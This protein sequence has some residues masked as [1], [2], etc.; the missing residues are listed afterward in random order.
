MA[1]MFGFGKRAA[2]DIA[3]TVR[4]VR[5][6]Y[7]NEI[8]QGRGGTSTNSNKLARITAV[9]PSNDLETGALVAE[10]ELLFCNFPEEEGHQV[11]TTEV[12]ETRVPLFAGGTVSNILE[13]DQIWTV[14]F[15]SGQWWLGNIVS[16]KPELIRKACMIETL[17]EGENFNAKFAWLMTSIAG[18][19]QCSNPGGAMWERS[20]TQICVWGD[21]GFRGVAFGSDDYV[22][23]DADSNGT[24]VDVYYSAQHRKWFALGGYT[25]LIGSVVGTGGAGSDITTP[26]GNIFGHGIATASIE[27]DAITCFVGDDHIGE[28]VICHW[29]N[30]RQVWYCAL[31]GCSIPDP[32]TTTTTTTTT[33]PIP[34][35][36]QVDDPLHFTFFSLEPCDFNE[37]EVLLDKISDFVWEWSGTLDCGDLFTVTYTCNPLADETGC[38]PFTMHYTFPCAGY[39]EDVGLTGCNCFGDFTAEVV[40]FGDESECECCQTPMPCEEN[41]C[42]TCV[43]IYHDEEH[44]FPDD[45]GWR[46]QSSSCV[47][48]CGTCCADFELFPPGA[49]EGQLYT[50]GCCDGGAH[51]CTGM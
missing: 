10:I 22:G 5:A 34:C 17:E 29:D 1:E 15:R 25:N 9:G 11:L 51:P 36:E 24:V 7:K 39:S 21:S 13:V 30:N 12:L 35:C 49:V 45:A 27:F 2:G 33:T 19:G 6:Q 18:D 4:T 37:Q 16:F 23:G 32:E 41:D 20:E 26:I 48:P 31:T 14:D 42:G 3:K 43:Y 50:V 46:I 40:D 47:L 8:P 38:N 44:A 28:E